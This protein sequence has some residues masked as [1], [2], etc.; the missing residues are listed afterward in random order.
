MRV[1]SNCI[2]GHSGK[3]PG[4]EKAGNKRSH[5]GISLSE[6]LIAKGCAFGRKQSTDRRDGR[7]LI[8]SQHHR[9]YARV[10]VRRPAAAQAAADQYDPL[11]FT[12]LH[13]WATASFAA[14]KRHHIGGAGT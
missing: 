10:F 4:R 8:A 13:R 2:G 5:C 14:G 7:E 1:T 11:T 6:A 3:E 9:T 12:V